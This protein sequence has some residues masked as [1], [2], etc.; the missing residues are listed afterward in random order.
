MK[1]IPT[2]RPYWHVDAKWITGILLAVALAG[3]L[4]LFTAARLTNRT[5]GPR[6]L[7]FSIGSVALQQNDST[8][9]QELVR[10]ALAHHQ[11]SV[12]PI[13]G[14]PTVNIS[15]TDLN[16]SVDE[17]KLKL[18][19]PVA[20]L[21][22]SKGVDG[23]AQQLFATPKEREQFVKQ[24]SFLKV[25]STDTHNRLTTL[26]NVLIVPVVVL[27]L[28]TIYFSRGWGRL[29]TPGVIGVLVGLPG[30]V[31]GKALLASDN[32]SATLPADIS[33][34]MGTVLSVGYGLVFRIGAVLLA[35]ALIGKLASLLIHGTHKPKGAKSPNPAQPGELPP[36]RK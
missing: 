6:L 35:L 1:F 14:F 7:A 36:V 19:A 20:T 27:L 17:L 4:L 8:K 28:L 3:C 32:S 9:I 33:H 25:V 11:T 26:Q 30:Y 31:A 22:Y 34:N 15:K 18:F 10:Q 2:P 16:L 12:R 29:A 21:I 23:A 13:E 24:A 5:N